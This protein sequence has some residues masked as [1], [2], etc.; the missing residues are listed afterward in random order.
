MLRPLRY[1]AARLAIT[2]DF[3]CI[4]TCLKLAI[5]PIVD[6][7]SP[8][9]EPTVFGVSGY[10]GAGTKPSPKNDLNVLKDNLLAYSLTGH[11]H[12]REISHRLGTSVG[13]VP[14]GE[15]LPKMRRNVIVS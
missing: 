8:D 2:A 10:S 7:I 6:H 9:A 4:L 15:S 14:H 13:F 12:E 3:D 1:V 5:A 11:V